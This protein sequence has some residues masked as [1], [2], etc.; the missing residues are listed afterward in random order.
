M[1]HFDP[2]MSLFRAST[3]SSFW[4]HPLCRET[5]EFIREACKLSLIESLDP[6]A[7][8]ASEQFHPK[9]IP[10]KG[11]LAPQ[12]FSG[13]RKN[14]K[15]TSNSNSCFLK[16]R[17]GKNLKPRSNGN[18]CFLRKRSKGLRVGSKVEH[19]QRNWILFTAP[20]RWLKSDCYSSPGASSAAFCSSQAPP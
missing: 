2:Q 10:T 9:V 17:E 7:T 1:R 5:E 3:M 16:K 18:S 11:C 8:G 15:A 20:T 12:W 19:F 14:L 13:E 4:A 6:H